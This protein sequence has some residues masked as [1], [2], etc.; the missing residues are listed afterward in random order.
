MEGILCRQVCYNLALSCYCPLHPLTQRSKCRSRWSFASKN[1]FLINLNL[2]QPI[3]KP[4]HGLQKALF[5]CKPL[6]SD[7]R[8][9]ADSEAVNYSR[10]QIDLVW[11]SSLLQDGLGFVAVLSREDGIR[12]RSSNGERAVYGRELSLGNHGRMSKIAHFDTINE[13]A[14]NVLFTGKSIRV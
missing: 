8:I 10:V 12:L 2:Q 14:N 1:P 3:V 11:V 5:L 9:T 7:G 6:D 13:V 4:G